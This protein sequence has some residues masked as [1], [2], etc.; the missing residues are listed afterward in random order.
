M[1][2]ALRHMNQKV[3]DFLIKKEGRMDMVNKE[4]QTLLDIA[5]AYRESSDLR[6][7]IPLVAAGGPGADLEA[8]TFFDNMAVFFRNKLSFR[9]GFRNRTGVR[10]QAAVNF[11]NDAGKWKTQ[12]W[13]RLAPGEDATVASSLNRV[14]YHYAE[15]RKGESTGTDI[16]VTLNGKRRGM[17]KL[18]VPSS[19]RGRVFYVNLK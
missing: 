13:F 8:R 18:T 16:Y 3:L 17:R 6:A 5:T 12:S 4:G 7:K 19:S 10:V 11:L 14:F 1:M 9:L 2:T 15:S